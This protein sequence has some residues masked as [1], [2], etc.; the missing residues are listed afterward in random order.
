MATLD[1]KLNQWSFYDIATTYL[2][3]DPHGHLLPVLTYICKLIVI[4]YGLYT[5]QQPVLLGA[6]AAWVAV[7]ICKVEE[8][9]WTPSFVEVER[10]GRKIIGLMSGFRSVFPNFRNPEKFCESGVLDRINQFIEDY[11]HKMI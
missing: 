3:S 8:P 9:R 2:A 1:Y 7:Q 11:E 10:Y 4:E 6:A 5:S